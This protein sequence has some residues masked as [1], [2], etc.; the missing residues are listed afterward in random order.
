MGPLDDTKITDGVDVEALV[1]RPV[2][3]P[4]LRVNGP[5]VVR[6]W[7]SATLNDTPA[8]S[9]VFSAPDQLWKRR[10]CSSAGARIPYLTSKLGHRGLTGRWRVYIM[11]MSGPGTSGTRIDDGSLT[12]ASHVFDFFDFFGSRKNAVPRR[13]R[14]SDVTT[15]VGNIAGP[16]QNHVLEGPDGAVTASTSGRARSAPWHPLRHL[17]P[18]LGTSAT[19]IERGQR[20]TRRSENRKTAIRPLCGFYNR[21]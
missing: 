13:A 4:P 15:E 1:V 20:Y 14:S 11:A 6:G 10:E 7:C 21:A 8:R 3:M 12:S 9:R 5:R 2:Q 18:L 19:P 16:R 17:G